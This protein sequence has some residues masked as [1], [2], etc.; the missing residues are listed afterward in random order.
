MQ[1]A[2]AWASA[3]MHSPRPE[4]HSCYSIVLVIAWPKVGPSARLVGHRGGFGEQLVRLD[5]AVVEAE[6]LGLLAA[7]D[8]AGVEQV[9]GAREADH[10]RQQ[11][12]RAHVGAGQADAHEQERELAA[13][14]RV[15]HVG[16]QAIIAPAPVQTPSIAAMIGCG[17]PRI[18]LTRSPVMRVNAS[19]SGMSILT[20]GPMISCTS[21]PEQ[22]LPPSP[23]NTTALTSVA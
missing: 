3:S 21:P 19:S 10:A 16:G 12:A 23:V 17:Q 13:R 6:A 7:D 22:K 2:C 20:S 18:A 4:L 1:I 14:R 15:A 8:A 5:Q 11:R 9:G